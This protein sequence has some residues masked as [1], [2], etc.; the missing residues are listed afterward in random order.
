MYMIKHENFARVMSE[1]CSTMKKETVEE[2]LQKCRKSL[3]IWRVL[4]DSSEE[5]TKD[6][7]K[8][9]QNIIYLIRYVY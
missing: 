4:C 1:A 8:N 6:I 7:K 2:K 9:Q 3:Y 5:N